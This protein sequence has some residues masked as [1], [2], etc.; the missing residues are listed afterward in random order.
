MM[1]RIQSSVLEVEAEGTHHLHAERV[2]D[3][4]RNMLPLQN[5]TFQLVPALTE[6]TIFRIQGICLQA[7][8]PAIESLRRSLLTFR[9]SGK[10]LIA[11]LVTANLHTY[12]LA[13]A[14][15]AVVA[16]ES[17]ELALHGL[18]AEA[19]FLRAALDQWGVRPQFHHIAEYKSAANRFI[20][21]TMPTSQREMLVEIHELNEAYHVCSDELDELATMTRGIRPRKVARHLF[22]NERKGAERAVRD[23]NNYAHNK[24]TARACRKRGD[25]ETAQMYDEDSRRAYAAW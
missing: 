8:L 10:R 5:Q 15:D 21:P 1:T 18:R 13:S 24:M 20:Y 23:L 12:Y 11:F 25:I 2:V 6:S 17:A 14:A 22:P 16:P 3:R 9:T 19:S 4:E 7:G